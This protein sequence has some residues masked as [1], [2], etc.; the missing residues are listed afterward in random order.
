MPAPVMGEDMAPKIFS[1][2]LLPSVDDTLEVC[3]LQ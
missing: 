3:C 2:L 1:K